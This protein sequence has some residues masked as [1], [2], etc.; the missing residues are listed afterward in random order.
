MRLVR[1]RGFATLDSKRRRVMGWC[2]VAGGI[3]VAAVAFR[4]PSS[5]KSDLT[6]ANYAVA[7]VGLL[8]AYFA[9]SLAMPKVGSWAGGTPFR[10]GVVAAALLLI[11]VVASA[12]VP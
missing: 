9:T 2:G 8:V 3:V 4:D 7:A 6:F 1:F 12:V 11:A 5:T 10:W